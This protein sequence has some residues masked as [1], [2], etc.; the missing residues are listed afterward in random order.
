MRS[1]VI[2][3]LYCFSFYIR[4]DDDSSERILFRYIGIVKVNRKEV[5]LSQLVTLVNLFYCA[6]V[7]IVIKLLQNDFTHREYS[8]AEYFVNKYCTRTVEAQKGDK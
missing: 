5:P 2:N 8:F 1:S 7:Y 4:A 6:R 3:R